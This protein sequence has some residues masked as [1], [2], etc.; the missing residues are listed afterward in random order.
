MIL[1]KQ[2]D[3]YQLKLKNTHTVDH[4]FPRTRTTLHLI[5]NVQILT[6]FVNIIPIQTFEN[7]ITYVTI[8]IIQNKSNIDQLESNFE[9]TNQVLLIL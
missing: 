7:G 1:K 6:Q 9:D 8:D 2:K 3:L 4:F 5:S